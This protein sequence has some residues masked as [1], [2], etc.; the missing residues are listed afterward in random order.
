MLSDEMT[1]GSV[2]SSEPHKRAFAAGSHGWNLAQ[3]RFKDAFPEVSLFV[4]SRPYSPRLRV[5]HP[6]QPAIRNIRL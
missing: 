4:A 1:T 5:S 3:P 6:A 2:T